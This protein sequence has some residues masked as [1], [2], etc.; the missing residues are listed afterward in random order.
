MAQLEPYRLAMTLA[1]KLNSENVKLDKILIN[2][3]NGKRIGIASPFQIK[4]KMH[5]RARPTAVKL[6]EICD[7]VTFGEYE[8]VAQMVDPGYSDDGSREFIPIIRL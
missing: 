3:Q 8:R 2:L 5:R 6:E 4:M 1:N 7:S